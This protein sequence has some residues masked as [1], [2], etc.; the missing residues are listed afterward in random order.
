ME[1]NESLF[2]L[3]LTL[4]RL[5]YSYYTRL[6]IIKL[7]LERHVLLLFTYDYKQEKHNYICA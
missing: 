2:T 3:F 1:G 5:Y 7:T 6:F 4:I